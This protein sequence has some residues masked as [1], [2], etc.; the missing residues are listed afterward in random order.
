R[1][2]L[3]MLVISHNLAV[4]RYV[5]DLIAMMYLGRIVEVGPAD[6][7]LDAP[8]HPYT[9]TL[10]VAAP[11][12]G[13]RL[14]GADADGAAVDGADPDGPDPG[15]TDLDGLDPEPADPH[16]PPSGS[17]FHP[18]CPV[19]PRLRSDRQA[20]L[21]S[22]PY[23]GAAGRRHRAACHFADATAAT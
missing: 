15:G 13:D 7:V 23:D 21:V 4:V 2:G 14:D 18:R 8:A 17:H 5:S 6:D 1:L 12:L 9:R 20:C 19:G 16:H 22:D 10:L 11:R 3:G